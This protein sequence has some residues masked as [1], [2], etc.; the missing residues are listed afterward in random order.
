MW[1]LPETAR[2]RR[3]EDAYD[4]PDREIGRGHYGIV[5]RAT[6]RTDGLA[7]AVKTIPKRRA[8]YVDMLKNEISILK[9]LDHI[10]I[11]RLHD[12]FEDFR[13]VHLVFEL[14]TGGELFEPIADANFRFSERQASRLVRKM[15]LAVK[16][17]HDRNVVHR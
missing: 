11:I 8:V 2:L 6:R 13:Q 9:S 17:C 5:R 16:Y 3:L 14:C 10:N 4:L 15:L 7:V 1:V 12:E